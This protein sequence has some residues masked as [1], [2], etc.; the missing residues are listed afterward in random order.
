MG[1][2]RFIL[3]S[4][5][6]AL[7]VTTA[8]EPALAKKPDVAGPDDRPLTVQEQG[9]S[10][11]KLAAAER[12]AASTAASGSDLAPLA[13]VEA[14]ADA[15]T[16]DA[17]A[18]APLNGPGTVG[19]GQA[20]A[21]PAGPCPLPVAAV[22]SDETSTFGAT[23]ASMVWVPQG[24]LGVE[25]RDQINGWYCGPAVGQVI[26]NYSWAVPAGA[27]K[28]VQRKIAEWMGT[29]VNGQTGAF[30]LAAGLE[31][32]TAG[33]PRRPANWAWI[34]TALVDS[35]GDGWRGDQLDAMVRS[36]ISNSR[37]PLAISVKPHDA[38]S[39]SGAHLL[40]WP[41]PVQ[42]VGHWV[43]IYGWVHIHDGS[44]RARMYYTDS[45]GDE[46]GATGKFWTPTRWFTLLIIE[47]TGR[48]VW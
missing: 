11:R 31:T 3:A 27:N 34:V 38:F 46:G 2:R 22:T 19:E 48:L 24:W 26:A 40:S 43:A 17:T 9:A 5:T 44:D 4:L 18:A 7:L 42:S 15:T 39:P 23:A 14:F 41:Q 47:H 20:P 10:D 25:A 28:Y 33:S 13:C 6:A 35:D 16:L 12:Y 32:A 21:P 29:D 45:S 30:A 1:S 36:N 8:A 37:M